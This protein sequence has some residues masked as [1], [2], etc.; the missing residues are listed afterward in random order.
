M[1]H[2]KVNE[3]CFI[4]N[5]LTCTTSPKTTPIGIELIFFSETA[6]AHRRF[7]LKRHHFYNFKRCKKGKKNKENKS[8]LEY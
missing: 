1:C 8:S 5:R 2:A 3:N 6:S 4:F 7:S